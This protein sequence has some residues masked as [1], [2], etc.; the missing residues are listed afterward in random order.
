MIRKTR[1]ENLIIQKGRR[2]SHF[3]CQ[4]TCLMGIHCVWSAWGPCGGC[5]AKSESERLLSLRVSF[6][7]GPLCCAPCRPSSLSGATSPQKSNWNR[8]GL[9]WE[10]GR[11]LHLY[12]QWVSE[13]SPG[14]VSCAW[15]HPVLCLLHL[16]VF[17]APDKQWE[18]A[19]RPIG[20]Q[21]LPPRPV[22]CV[23]TC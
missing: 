15:I 20:L 14:S 19:T 1:E 16:R 5:S 12:Y 6:S 9:E 4:H 10:A 18:L 21:W 2:W 7:A 13:Q 22:N 11:S 8:P 3:Y 17:S 23:G